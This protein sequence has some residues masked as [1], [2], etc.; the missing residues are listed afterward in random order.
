MTKVPAGRGRL[1][2]AQQLGFSEVPTISLDHLTPAQARAF[3]IADN[4][5]NVL[6]SWDERLLGE[7]FKLLADLDLDFSLDVTGFESAKSIC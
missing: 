5:L 7:Q 3:A 6:S 2:A 4:R 1:L